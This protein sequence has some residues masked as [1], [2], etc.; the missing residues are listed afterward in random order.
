[1]QQIDASCFIILLHASGGCSGATRPSYGPDVPSLGEVIASN[2]R[3]ERARRRWRQDDLA[4][5][6]GWSR[7]V[8][9]FLES[10]RRNVLADDLPRLCEALEVD[11]AELTRGADPEDLRRL[12]L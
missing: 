8:L 12:G 1:M 10:G 9:S 6:L 2:V 4:E 11:L 7:Q 5:R 3:A